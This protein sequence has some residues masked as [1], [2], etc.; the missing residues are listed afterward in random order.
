[1]QS[2]LNLTRCDDLVG[3]KAGALRINVLGM[4]AEQNYFYLIPSHMK[5]QR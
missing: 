2:L 1:M 3:F 4:D 5:C